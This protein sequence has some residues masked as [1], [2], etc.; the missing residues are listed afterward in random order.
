MALALND[1][2]GLK[3]AILA[4][5]GRPHDLDEQAADQRMT[6]AADAAR[7]DAERSTAPGPA[8]GQDVTPRGRRDALRAAIDRAM[9]G[10]PEQT[11]DRPTPAASRAALRRAIVAAIADTGT[12]ATDKD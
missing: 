5:V 7:R 4:A 11:P 6:D 9:Q 3:A 8:V 10:E 1:D 12:N 2:D